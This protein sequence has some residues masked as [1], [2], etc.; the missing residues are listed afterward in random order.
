MSYGGIPLDLPVPPFSPFS[1]FI[2]LFCFLLEI[3]FASH[4]SGVIVERNIQ[5]YL[6]NILRL[7]SAVGFCRT[8][9]D[10]DREKPRLYHALVSD[11]GGDIVVQ[12]HYAPR[13]DVLQTFLD[14]RFPVLRSD[15]L[16]YRLLT[17]KEEPTAT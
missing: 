5:K 16:R 10:L 11:K 13:P 3:A 1:S 2:D 8:N 7:L 9:T 17:Q 15:F 12:E 14:L 4:P 6:A